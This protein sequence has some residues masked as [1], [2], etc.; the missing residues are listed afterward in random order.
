MVVEEATA[1]VPLLRAEAAGL[2][3]QAMPWGEAKVP[4]ARAT[5]RGAVAGV[6]PAPGQEDPVA[7]KAA[8][9]AVAAATREDDACVQLS[10]MHV[11]LST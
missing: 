11:S 5:A 9:R 10:C 2:D 4:E 8:A 3:V 7:V 1:A 6:A